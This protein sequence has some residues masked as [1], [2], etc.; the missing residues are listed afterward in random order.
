MSQP[1]CPLIM[2][3]YVAF[4]LDHPPKSINTPE[5]LH[6]PEL[7]FKLGLT[8]AVDI[9]NLGCTVSIQSDIS[10]WSLRFQKD[11]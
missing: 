3:P 9:W 5:P 11:V 2:S 10:S 4:F 8:K 7:V 1:Y 6:P